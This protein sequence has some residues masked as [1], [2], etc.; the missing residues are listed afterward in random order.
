MPSKRDWNNVPNTSA[1]VYHIPFD[2][3][4]SWSSVVA[5]HLLQAC[6][7]FVCAQG[8]LTEDAAIDFQLMRSRAKIP[9]GG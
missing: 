1:N 9:D 4:C 8:T 6:S 3:L 7:T 2:I 5:H